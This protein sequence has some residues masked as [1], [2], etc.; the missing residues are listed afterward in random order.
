MY[1]S[2]MF[3]ILHL[4]RIDFCRMLISQPSI[5]SSIDYRVCDKLWKVAGRCQQYNFS[6]HNGLACSRV[7]NKLREAFHK[8]RILTFVH[9]PD[10]SCW[11]PASRVNCNERITMSEVFY[12]AEKQQGLFQVHASTSTITSKNITI[13]I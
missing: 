8:L 3:Q 5:K 9:C 2:L 11:S 6:K 7:F 4:R 10:H 12:D 1:A 13:N